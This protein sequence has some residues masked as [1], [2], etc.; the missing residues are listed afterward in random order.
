MQQERERM[1]VESDARERYDRLA[2]FEADLELLGLTVEE[3]VTMH[4]KPLPH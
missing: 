3:A 1:Q 2:L 4:A